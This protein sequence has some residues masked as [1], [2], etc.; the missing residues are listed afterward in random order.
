MNNIDSPEYQNALKRIIDLSGNINKNCEI[1]ASEEE[2]MSEYQK[3]FSPSNIK[4]IEK[5]EFSLFLN[6]TINNHRTPLDRHV[7]DL[8][9]NVKGM[10]CSMHFPG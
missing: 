10:G 8:T 3:L 5:D 9:R 4:N 1:L 7:E 2:V 6:F